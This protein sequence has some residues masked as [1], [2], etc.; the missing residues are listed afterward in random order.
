M[1]NPKGLLA[2]LA[3]LFKL[4]ASFGLSDSQS[5]VLNLQAVL[6]GSIPAIAHANVDV[7]NAAIKI[8]LDVQMLSG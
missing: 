1:I 7:R 2:Q 5:S 3:L 8:V 4:L 6:N